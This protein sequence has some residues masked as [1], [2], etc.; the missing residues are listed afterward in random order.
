[1]MNV[2]GFTCGAGGDGDGDGGD[3]AGAGGAFGLDPPLYCSPGEAVLL[4]AAY[5]ERWHG[6]AGVHLCPENDLKIRWSGV[7]RGCGGGRGGERE[8]VSS[9]KHAIFCLLPG[10]IHVCIAKKAS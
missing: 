9:R 10:Q 5:G 4:M 2:P 8:S 1:M 6:V 7:D 3:G